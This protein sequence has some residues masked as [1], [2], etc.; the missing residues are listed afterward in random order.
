[1]AKKYKPGQKVYHPHKAVDCF[2]IV[3]KVTS[4][5]KVRV[6]F[7]DGVTRY[8]R[9]GTLK[10]KRPLNREPKIL[11]EFTSDQKKTIKERAAANDLPL[12]DVILIL[13]DCGQL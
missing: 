2:G 5:G 3:K 7:F 1:M 9:P 10:E 8:C 12:R 6:E 11:Q 13:K 4:T